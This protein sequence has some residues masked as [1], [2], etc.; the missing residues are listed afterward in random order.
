MD[1][2][3][4]MATMSDKGNGYILTVVDTAPCYPEAVALAKIETEKVAEALLEVFRRI[5]FP[6]D[7]LSD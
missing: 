2:I 4:S 7:L 3:G 6:Q 1:L 5:S